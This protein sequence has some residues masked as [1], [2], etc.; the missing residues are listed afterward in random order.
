MTEPPP[1]ADKT[2]VNV[3]SLA[4]L[5]SVLP[6]LAG[7]TA[8]ELSTLT[9]EELLSLDVT[10]VGKKEQ[11]L[12]RV[13]AA[14]FVITQEDIRRMGATSIPEALRIVPGLH[15]AKINGR[16]WA[17][18]SRGFN[19]VFSTKLLVM[20]DG[21]SIYTPLFA[22]VWW[23]QDVMI[24]D[25]DRIEIIRGPAAAIWGAN[26]VNG[27]IHIITKKTRQTVGRL[28]S[29]T[30]GNEDQSIT[31]FR[32]GGELGGS[33]HYR[34]Y[35]QYSHRF[36][37][38]PVERFSDT[39]WGTLQ[40]GFRL[41]MSPGKEQELTVQADIAQGTGF[42]FEHDSYPLLIP[43]SVTR[44][45]NRRNSGDV[46]GR[47]S[48]THR[49]GARTT[50]Q[51]YFDEVNRF[52]NGISIDVHTIDGEVQHRKSISQKHE[53]T[54]SSGYRGILDATSGNTYARLIPAS[55]TYGI[56]QLSMVDDIE[57]WKDR[58]QLT[59]GARLEHNS[60]SRFSVQPT[61]RLQWS[62][63]RHHSLWGA[64]SRAIR[65]P[66][67]LD[68]G[69]ERVYA[70]TGF[71]VRSYEGHT[72]E[73]LKAIDV[74]YRGNITK[75]VMLD[76]AG[77][78]N[79]YDSLRSTESMGFDARQMIWWFNLMNLAKAGS[80]G[81]EGVLSVDLTSRW[82][83]VGSYT[84]LWV[85]NSLRPESTDVSWLGQ[86]RAVPVHQWQIQ[87]NIAITRNLK[88]NSFLYYYGAARVN[89]FP[90]GEDYLPQRVRVDSNFTW[91]P[92]EVVEFSVGARNL[93]GNRTPEYFI[94]PGPAPEAM[95]RTIYGRVMW[96]F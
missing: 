23:D 75:R 31:R 91:R 96:R 63:S 89:H 90:V 36:L 62:I 84:G 51:G 46:L 79:S 58:L 7:Q 38:S 14:V 70:A 71:G 50:V 45:E 34:I 29:T 35:G 92:G 85:K 80:W 68:G 4:L 39:Y 76:V 55:M 49:S 65:S 54:F 69:L 52:S 48:I 66:A 10:T 8:P 18:T 67:R 42:E 26:A 73:S 40:A 33:G 93:S 56:A 47:W 19:S 13:A 94:E 6:L 27:L 59:V 74:G 83:M 43:A 2:I 21:R 20:I 60:F 72:A 57:L 86:S 1:S 30:V 32:H 17:I 28:L 78:R 44:F 61:L 11:R 3:F 77:F 81:A 95:R 24:D 41:D 15:V 87:S 25:V 37:P 88:W 9:L 82:R 16:A 53:L 64:V 5:V 12:G 22:G